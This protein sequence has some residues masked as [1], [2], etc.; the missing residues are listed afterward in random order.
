VGQRRRGSKPLR[1]EEENKTDRIGKEKNKKGRKGERN[2]EKRARARTH[3]E[4]NAARIR[5]NNE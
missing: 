4:D 3:A 1:G 5:D 2:R